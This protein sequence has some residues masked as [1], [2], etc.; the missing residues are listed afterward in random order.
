MLRVRVLIW[1]YV[2]GYMGG[3]QECQEVDKLTCVGEDGTDRGIDRG[4]ESGEC[5][6]E[7]V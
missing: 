3:N 5:M 2:C 6:W 4:V 7:G 1:V